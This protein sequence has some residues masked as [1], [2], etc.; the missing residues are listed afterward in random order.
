MRIPT[1]LFF[2]L[3]PLAAAA[4]SPV[5]NVSAQ[6]RFPWNGLVDITFR[7]DASAIVTVSATDAET[8]TTLSVNTMTVE[9]REF[10]NGETSLDAGERH[11]VWNAGA[12]VPGAVYE[13]VEV[14]VSAD[15]KLYM[16]VD[17]SRKVDGKYPVSYLSGPPSGGWKS[18]HKT[19]KLVLRKI[20]AGTFMMGSPSSA[21]GRYSNEV[22]HQVTLT[23]DYYLSIFEITQGQTYLACGTSAT[24]CISYWTP[25]YPWHYINYGSVSWAHNTSLPDTFVGKLNSSTELSFS[26]PT[27]AQWEYACRAGT[28]TSLYTGSNPKNKLESMIALSGHEIL[29]QVD[30]Q[31]FVGDRHSQ[32]S[33]EGTDSTFN[34]APPKAAP[35]GSFSPN[36]WGLYDMLG[37][38]PEIVKDT[39]KASLSGPVV[40]PCI[41]S[42]SE[43]VGK[44]AGIGSADRDARAAF[45]RSLTNGGAFRVVAIVAE[46]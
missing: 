42:G 46:P 36:P 2:L 34:G 24:N 16:V 22:Q 27:E 4:A 6:Q 38:R 45:R 12:D 13:N 35:V 39:Y 20:K 11:I 19:K 33:I 10:K 44:G 28:T 37:N 9:G 18:E 30:N 5:S 15:E 21:W 29:G 1:P 17:L 31:N 32:L 41:T 14:S 25:E 7:L 3:L 26:L 23:Q 40:D 43:H 8:G